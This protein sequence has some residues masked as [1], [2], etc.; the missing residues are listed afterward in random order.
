MSAPPPVDAVVVGAGLA[1]LTAADALHRAGL[2]VAV[3]E[4]RASVGGRIKTLVQDGA[5]F[6]L[7]ATWHWSNQPRIRELAGALGMEVFPQFRDGKAVVED[8]PRVAPRLVD[9]P[10]PSPAELR[11]AGGAQDLC[12]RLAARLPQGAVSLGAE[13]TLVAARDGGMTVSAT[14]GTGDERH[15]ACSW[16]VVAVPPRL[17]SAGIAFVPPLPE[18]TVE[19]M[20]GTP[21]WMATAVKCVAV[22][23]RAFWREAG[24]SGLAF[25]RVGPLVEVHDACTADGSAAALWG[26]VSADHALRDL[27]PDERR[28]LVFA[29]LGRL[30]G[31]EAADP[32]QYFERDWSDDPYTNDE[33][34]W[35]GDP[36]DYG[37]PALTEPAFAGR[38]VWAGTE[39][40]EVGAGHM[41]GAVRSGQRAA[42]RI[43]AQA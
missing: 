37:Q 13:V 19:A 22:Y 3:L 5:W 35:F 8:E 34:V 30:F 18:A 28:P 2:A 20:E 40:A 16:V 23:E 25:S 12:R 41:E 24:C 7:G 21:T 29:Q 33:V 15:V 10:P 6:D 14:S 17:A 11:F 31:A 42:A 9:L 43:L 38:L 1:G 4:A 36:L 39:T 26:F 32:V 27:G